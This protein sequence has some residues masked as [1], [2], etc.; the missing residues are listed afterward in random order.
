MVRAAVASAHAP[1]FFTE[2]RCRP[3]NRSEIEAF[4]RRFDM[5]AEQIIY[6]TDALLRLP[7]ELQAAFADYAAGNDPT[8]QI[9][10]WTVGQVAGFAHCTYVD[11]F[12]YL[13]DML[14]DPTFAAQFADMEFGRK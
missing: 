14:K 3:L 12:L 8:L 1:C 5:P 7:P 10:G 9:Y 6:Y 11:A 4:L 2:K 13:D